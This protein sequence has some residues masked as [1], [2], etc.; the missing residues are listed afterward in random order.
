MNFE[1]MPE[2]AEKRKGTVQKES[3]KPKGNCCCEK[4]PRNC[5]VFP[6][7]VSHTMQPYERKLSA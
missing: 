3:D 1:K 2:S 4:T 7:G 5:G 6:Y